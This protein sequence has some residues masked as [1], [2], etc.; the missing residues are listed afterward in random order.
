MNEYRVSVLPGVNPV[1]YQEKTL[2]FIQATSRESAIAQVAKQFPEYPYQRIELH[3]KS[4]LGKYWEIE[5]EFYHQLPN[6]CKHPECGRQLSKSNRSGYCKK[7]REFNPERFKSRRKKMKTVREILESV[8]I[9]RSARYL[10]FTD[11]I[12][13]LDDNGNP[14]DCKEIASDLIILYGLDGDEW[15]DLGSYR[16][17]GHQVEFYA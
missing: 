14:V 7:H 12:D 5:K 16:D 11:N 10:E 15:A 1:V 9:K 8:I 4:E 13:W 17:M 2:G 6:I 3:T